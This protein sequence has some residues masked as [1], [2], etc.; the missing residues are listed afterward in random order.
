M[1]DLTNLIEWNEFAHDK[2]TVLEVLTILNNRH[3]A[4]VA[5]VEAE[6]DQLSRDL[7]S[8][9]AADCLNGHD[10]TEGAQNG[11]AMRKAIAEAVRAFKPVLLDYQMED[12]TMIPCDLVA[13][14]ESLLA[15]LP[16]PQTTSLQS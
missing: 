13:A 15:F 2:K 9:L 12:G 14:Y 11:I 8:L 5:A 1:N 10:A 4:A 7:S 3:R 6:R 16:L